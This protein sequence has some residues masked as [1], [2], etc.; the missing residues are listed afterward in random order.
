VQD[1]G[2]RA[3]EL[4][5]CEYYPNVN[6]REREQPAGWDRDQGDGLT[7]HLS[8]F[9]RPAGVET[10]LSIKQL[11]ARGLTSQL[12]DMIAAIEHLHLNSWS[13]KNESNNAKQVGMALSIA[14]K[15]PSG[16]GVLSTGLIFFL[17]A[18]LEL[19]AGRRCDLRN[20]FND[21]NA[22]ILESRRALGAAWKDGARRALTIRSLSRTPRLKSLGQT[23]VD[24]QKDMCKSGATSN[25]W[26]VTDRHYIQSQDRTIV[27]NGESINYP[28]DPTLKVSKSYTSPSSDK[29]HE[30][31]SEQSPLPARVGIDWPTSR[32]ALA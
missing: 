29:L 17:V 28:R 30:E 16:D 31:L 7:S 13:H 1:S 22:G 24:N 14:I 11:T 27:R 23:S 10:G 25:V 4:I 3:F 32:P 18:L 26:E 19:Q 21:L 6:G 5:L 15:A 20:L 9:A 8:T 12:V 2:A